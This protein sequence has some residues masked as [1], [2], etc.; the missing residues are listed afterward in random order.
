M[1]D[2]LSKEQ[3]LALK[4]A[5]YDSRDDEIDLKELFLTLW[6]GKYIIIACTLI[7]T[8]IA[9]YYAL[10]AKVKNNWQVDAII[11]V[12]Q[13]SEFSAYQKLVQDFQPVFD[14]YHQSEDADND[15]LRELL[16]P[17]KLFEIFVR[18]YQSQANKRVFIYNAEEFQNKV[19]SFQS[20]GQGGEAKVRELELYS[21]WSSSLT[22]E[23]L[24]EKSKEYS[25]I[26]DSESFL[27]QARNLLELKEYI[28]FVEQR[29]QRLAL[30]N[31]KAIILAKQSELT[32]KKE[33]LIGLDKPVAVESESTISGSSSEHRSI[34]SRLAEVSSKLDS[35]ESTIIPDNLEFSTV[36]FVKEPEQLLSRTYPKKKLIVVLGVLLGGMLGCVIV[37][38]RFAFREK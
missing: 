36:S 13:V 29:S 9:S 5:N 18:Q 22:S 8:M 7:C 26:S 25:Q 24:N 23:R 12:P 16:E 21:N 32:K 10:N 27:L 2:E 14:S 37:L 38:I 20:D 19:V 15:S 11:T 4:Y 33:L 30:D 6:Q 28:S 1:R 34:V 3:L 17:L 35:I 31:L